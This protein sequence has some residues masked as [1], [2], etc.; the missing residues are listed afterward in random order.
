[1]P[2][3]PWRWQTESPPAGYQKLSWKG[4]IHGRIVTPG[5]TCPLPWSTFFSPITTGVVAT[6][7]ATGTYADGPQLKL[8][9]PQRQGQ[10]SYA[11]SE[12]YNYRG[13]ILFMASGRVPRAGSFIE[14]RTDERGPLKPK[15]SSAS[16]NLGHDAG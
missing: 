7:V 12:G 11:N 4:R 8:T 13:S 9:A 15:E 6:N 2:Q 1:M 5:Q 3:W 10:E 14:G 16:S